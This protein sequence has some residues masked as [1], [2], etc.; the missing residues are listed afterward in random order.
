MKYLKRIKSDAKKGKAPTVLDHSLPGRDLRK[1]LA[2]RGGATAISFGKKGPN[3]LNKP[4]GVLADE[5][6]KASNNL[7][8]KR[9][10]YGNSMITSRLLGPSQ[11]NRPSHLNLPL[12][13]AIFSIVNW[14]VAFPQVEGIQVMCTRTWPFLLE[15]EQQRFTAQKYGLTEIVLKAMNAFKHSLDLHIAGLHTLV[16]LGRP[17]GGQEGMV[18]DIIERPLAIGRTNLG[19]VALLDRSHGKRLNGVSKVLIVLESMQRFAFDEKLQATA[20][21]AIVN[22]AL[23]STQKTILISHGGIK[24]ITNAMMN[25]PKSY[26][27]QFRAL[28][29]LI[30]LAI[31]CKT[32]A[33]TKHTPS[34]KIERRVLDESVEEMCTLVVAALRNFHTNAI[35][36][37]R[38]CLVLHNL[39]LTPEYLPTLLW[40]PF[41]YKMLS[42]SSINYD[43]DHVLGRSALGGKRR[44]DEF[45][46]KD[47]QLR[48][49][50]TT[51][52]NSEASP[53]NP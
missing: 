53:S 10:K 17:L 14:M 33:V 24:A 2:G 23:V 18:V 29:A 42:E 27:V 37:N 30:N 28:F 44:L 9:P 16:L 6:N 8:T 20:C 5:K 3:I 45:L 40:T 32:S 39:S 13:C 47:S 34:Q 48:L 12:P 11:D 25:H 35:I 38:A 15:D 46:S 4:I 21:W 1:I 36:R 41:C 49:R 43:S 22:L 31:P 7:V 51:W 19:T 50:F 52:I 26:E